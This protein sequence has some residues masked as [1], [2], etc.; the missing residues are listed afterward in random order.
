MKNITNA[1]TRE[2]TSPSAAR[3]DKTI[4]ITTNK[5]MPIPTATNDQRNAT[6]LLLFLISIFLNPNPCPG[7]GHA[8]F[9]LISER[10][11]PDG[12]CPAIDDSHGALLSNFLGYRA[13]HP[14][15]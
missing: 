7:F 5:I 12:A 4:A 10:V 1:T 8:Y 9:P 15:V 6:L 2:S 3:M 11:F 13:S 14:L